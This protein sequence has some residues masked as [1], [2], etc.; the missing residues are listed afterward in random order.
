VTEAEPSAIGTLNE[1]SLHAALKQLVW[2]PGDEVEVPL[3]GFVI[4]LRRQDLLIE[5]QT[6]SFGAMGNKLDQLLGDHR[7]LIIHP[8]ATSTYL[9]RGSAKPRRS[10]KR[11]SLWSMLDE[12]VSLPSMVD[13]PNLSLEVWLVSVDRIQEADPRARRG[14]GG[15][16]TVDRRLRE[17]EHRHRFD[18]ADDVA[19]L[20]PENL[21][22]VFT[23]ADVAAAASVPRDGAQKLLYCLRAMERVELI[24]RRRD[25]FHYRRC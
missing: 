20:L 19:A 14:R 2:Q 12:L 23:T 18:S 8:V 21:P 5:I 11:G 1:G 17:V 22:E 13:H 10:P 6:G 25:G 3:N 4:D 9:H 16:R 24:D 7:V 15:W